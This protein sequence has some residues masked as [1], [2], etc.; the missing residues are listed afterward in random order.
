MSNDFYTGIYNPDVLS[1]LA[2]LSNDEVFTSPEIVN[3]MLD[4][5]PQEI[6]NNPN[7][8]FLDPAC[9]SGVFLR[10]IAKRLIA[11][12]EPEIPD[13]QERI[14]HIFTKQ[15]FG[16]AITELTSLLS[17]RSTYCSKFPNSIYSV[18]KFN[19]AQGNIRY[20]KIEHLW[21][22]GKCMF[23]GASITLKRSEELESHAYEFIHTTKPEEIFNMKFDVIV[24]N[25][26][27]QLNVGIQKENYAVPIYQKFVQQAKK[28]NPRFLV[29]ITPSRWFTG[30][31]KLDDYR[32]EML[33]DSRIR[34][35]VDYVDS[36]ECFPGVDIAGGVNYFLWDRDYSGTCEF[37]SVHDGKECVADRRLNEF[38]IFP[39]YNEALSII[40]KVMAK[41]EPLMSEKVSMQTPFGFITTFRG[42][43][44]KF[45]NCIALKSSKEETYVTVSEV[46]K[47]QDLIPKYK[48]IF[49][50]ATC[51]HAGIPDRNGQYRVVSTNEI[52]PPGS[53][54]TQTYLIADSFDKRSEAENCLAYMRTKFMRF[55]LLQA[56]TSQDI[57]RDK[58]A[59]VP[60]QDFSKKYSDEELYKKYGLSNEEI[61]FIEST[62][63]PMDVED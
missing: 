36:K 55:L 45:D 1:C 2:N 4:E 37:V 33:N 32:I 24:G 29:M 57:S 9:K 20:K 17:R 48:V 11:G 5:L 49:S 38:S 14:D 44:R 10:E 26:P 42:K 53:V 62:I 59:F 40:H 47:N 52:L 50:K 34:K 19:D 61:D 63:K 46:S 12:L 21:K 13:L 54:C 60:A 39:R 8:T 22:D 18:C 3:R 25:P 35:I 28:L 56:L 7:T 58:F 31:R 6:F 27:Y 16:I 41:K 30:G 51:E 15:L 23:C 43:A